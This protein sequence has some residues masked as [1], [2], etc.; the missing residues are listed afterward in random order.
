MPPMEEHCGSQMYS[1]IMVVE[2]ELSS[3]NASCEGGALWSRNSTITV[4]ES[5]LHNNNAICEGGALW[6]ISS[7]VIVSASVLHSNTGIEHGGA[8]SSV[9]STVTI[10]NS[11]LY[12]NL[13]VNIGYGVVLL[14]SRYSAI[15][16]CG[17]IFTDNRAFAGAVHFVS[18]NS[19]IT[20]NGSVVMS[21]NSAVSYGIVFLASSN[22]QLC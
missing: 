10:G 3:N 9:R 5:N 6:F 12:S 11:L 20:Y 13:A 22:G 18:L 4:T 19:N 8:V 17:S 7:T 14:R 1:I 16:I 15:V 2:S 21:N